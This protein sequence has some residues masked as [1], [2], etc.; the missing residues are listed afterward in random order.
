MGTHQTISARE[1]RDGGCENDFPPLYAD[2]DGTLLKSDLLVESLLAV[3]RHNPARLLEV[4]LWLARG[5]AATKL[6]AHRHG[7]VRVDTLP[8]NEAMIGYLTQQK[9]A[10]RKLYLATAAN[11]RLASRVAA[12]VG[13]F[14]GVIASGARGNL[15]GAAKLDKILS[16]QA[17][18]PFAY[19]GNSAADRT[20]WKAAARCVFVNAP[21]A[22]VSDAERDGKVEHAI[23]SEGSALAALWKALRPH[24]WAKNLLIFVPLVTAHMYGS[25]TAVAAAALAFV[26]FCLGASAIYLIN[27]LLDL[28]DDRLHPRKRNRPFAS[29]ALS[30][31]VGIVLAPAMLASA[32]AI[33]WL[34]VGEPFVVTLAIYVVVSLL[35][36]FWFKRVSTIDVFAL[37]G[38]YTV[39]VIAGSAAIAAVPTFWLFAF[40]MFLFLSLAFVKRY[41]ELA[42]QRERGGDRL[43]GRGYSAVDL[44]A[45]FTLG[46]VSGGLAVLVMA[47]YI[48]SPEVTQH[49]ETPQFLWGLC[50]AILYWIN[51]IW[52]GARRGKVHDD[53]VVFA[54]RDRVSLAT[55][56]LCLALV[57]AAR[58]L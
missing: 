17:G 40:S 4:P 2:L 56:V 54:V 21:D 26:T 44:E 16:Q 47:L 58:Y 22:A 39:R 15:K 38:L 35:Y 43:S 19:A 51:R 3:A 20:I 14:D 25:G 8:Y 11:K 52:I 10:G 45:T 24:Q 57:A 12:H 9:R 46:A 6:L 5:R 42:Q 49:Y 13:L 34:A 53:P 23:R 28:Q 55:G 32:F 29:G 31:L 36:A 48:N 7:P 30:P 1:E 33:A 50:P 18:E 41:I 37:A 27:D